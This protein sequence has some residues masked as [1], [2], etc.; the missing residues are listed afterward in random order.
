L[1]HDFASIAICPH[2]IFTPFLDKASFKELSLRAL[3]ESFFLRAWSKRG[4]VAMLLWPASK[5]FQFLLNFR[6]GLYAMGYRVP[7]KLSVPV[8][9]VGN[10]FVGGTGKT[11][12]VIALL[13]QLRSAGWHPGVISRG[14]ASSLETILNVSAQSLASEVGDEPLLIAQRTS[15]PIMVGRDRVAT[16]QQLLANFPQ[17]NVIISDDG[18][19]HYALGRD[20][21][22]VMFDERG[23]G[24]G[25]LLPAGPLR[26]SPQRRRDFTVLNST[27]E[28]HVMGIGDDVYKMRLNTSGA[29]QLNDPNKRLNFEQIKGKRI[30]AAAGIGNPERFFK[31]LRGFSLEFEAMPL[32][33]HFAFTELSFAQKQAEIILV[34]E[35]DAVKCQQIA[36]IKDDLRVWVVPVSAQMESDF[37]ERLLAMI[38]EKKNGCSTT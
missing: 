2:T 26:E 29:F 4:L 7:T 6:F 20:V 38:S 30:L 18:L 13:E 27:T 21:E 22:I 16:A 36:R 23:I 34:T 10:I 14:Y 9:V 32:P 31:L 28:N 8:I 12:M 33:D 11:P 25:W 15:A 17:V 3:L 5:I 24:N 1:N 19:Q 37:M 35:K